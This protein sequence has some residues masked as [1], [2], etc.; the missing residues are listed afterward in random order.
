MEQSVGPLSSWIGRYER[1]GGRVESN[2]ICEKYWKVDCDICKASV[3]PEAS[4]SSAVAQAQ[5]SS[6]REQGPVVVTPEE[7]G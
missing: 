7:A 4:A 6:A 3:W 2:R 5:V 1:L